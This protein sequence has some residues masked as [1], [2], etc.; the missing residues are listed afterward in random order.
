MNRQVGDVR[1]DGETRTGSR[2]QGSP[3]C[4][5][6]GKLPF[7]IK[8][9]KTKQ[10]TKQKQAQGQEAPERAADVISQTPRNT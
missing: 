2:E 10:K 9:A 4:K 8:H 6:K 7:V 5:L 1:M 3:I